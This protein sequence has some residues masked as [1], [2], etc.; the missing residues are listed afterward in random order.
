MGKTQIPVPG[1]LRVIGSRRQLDDLSVFNK[2][3]AVFA[4]MYEISFA[5]REDPKF[6]DA[7]RLATASAFESRLQKTIDNK[8][9]H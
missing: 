4:N 1:C 2:L 9:A 5:P 6:A 3:G 8:K 7:A